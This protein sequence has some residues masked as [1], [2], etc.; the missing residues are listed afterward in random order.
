M[1]YSK[2]KL[3]LMETMKKTGWL[4]PIWNITLFIASN[5]SIKTGL[6]SKNEGMKT[7]TSLSWGLHAFNII[8]YNWNF[9]F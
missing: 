7:P 5:I 2:R 3:S 6:F 9:Y 8:K 1:S 4:D